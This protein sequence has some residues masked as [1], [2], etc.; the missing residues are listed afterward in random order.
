MITITITGMTTRMTTITTDRPA[1]RA[2]PRAAL[3]R[4]P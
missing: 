3:S 2:I 1:A 4:T